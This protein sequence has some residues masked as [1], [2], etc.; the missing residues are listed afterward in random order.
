M[1]FAMHEGEPPTGD[2][3]PHT[4]AH[5]G[6]TQERAPYRCP[7][8]DAAESEKQRFGQRKVTLGVR[9]RLSGLP[10]MIERRQA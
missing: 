7:V 6:R 3:H 8:A 4:H 2:L 1:Y 9:R 5:A 10:K